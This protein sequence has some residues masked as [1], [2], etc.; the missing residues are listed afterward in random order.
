MF[1]LPYQWEALT[2]WEA[3]T[4]RVLPVR[5]A[6]DDE[7]FE[8]L[9][10]E[11]LQNTAVI[12]GDDDY[13]N[14]HPD[15]NI[16]YVY[17]FSSNGFM[18]YVAVQPVGDSGPFVTRI[19]QICQTCPLYQETYIDLPLVCRSNSGTEYNLAQSAYATQ[20]GTDLSQ[21][22]GLNNQDD[23]TVVIVAFS[24]SDGTS[25]TPTDE[26][27][28]CIY[29][30]KT[31]REKYLEWINDC[32]N[33]ADKQPGCDWSAQ[34]IGIDC[35]TG[36]LDDIIG[37][38]MCDCRSFGKMT[39]GSL[40]IV[41][42]A[43]FTTTGSRVT[44]VAA[45]TYLS[46]TVMFTGDSNGQLKKMKVTSGT[47]ATEYE[48]IAVVRDNPEIVQNGLVFDN[49][50][51]FIYVMSKRQ[52]TKVPVENCEQYTN[53][54][55]CTAIKGVGDPY[56][57]WCSLENKCSRKAECAGSN[58]ENSNRWIGNLG[59]CPS[60]EVEPAS[61]ERGQ[62]E[63]LS[64]TVTSL[65][66][67]SG[68]F[69][70]VFA[71]LGS[72][73]AVKKEQNGN[74]LACSTPSP[75]NVPAPGDRG[76]VRVKLSLLADE[77]DVNFVS[78]DFDF[79]EC[80]SF[81]TCMA[82]T[83]NSYGCDWCIFENKCS[84]D[85]TTCREEG[86][87]QGNANAEGS[88][89]RCPQITA[90]DEILIP[91]DVDQEYQVKGKNFP[92]ATSGQSG[93]QC[94]L[95]I[96]GLEVVVDGL[97]VD[98]QTVRCQSAK[99][100]YAQEVSNKLVP[101]KL[102][103]NSGFDVDNPDNVQVNLYKC[104]VGRSN[105][106]VCHQADLKYNC[107]WCESG[108]EEHKCTVVSKCSQVTHWLTRDKICPDPTITEIKPMAGPVE[109]GTTLTIRGYNL[110]KNASNV[111]EVTVVG[112]PCVPVLSGYK[113]AEQVQCVT[114]P[115]GS[116][117]SG[118]VQITIGDTGDQ[119][120]YTDTST[121][122]F[123]YVV[124]KIDGLNPEKGPQS[125]GTIVT[126]SGENLNAGSV[127]TANVA[128]YPCH[129]TESSYDAITCVTS[130]SD[131]SFPS[132]GVTVT[133]DGVTKSN[134]DAIYR[135]MADPVIQQLS[136]YEAFV[137]GG[138][139]IEVK[140]GN[141][142]I[143]HTRIMRMYIKGRYYDAECTLKSSTLMEC[144]TP[145]VSASGIQPTAEEPYECDFGF[146]MDSVATSNR[147]RGSLESFSY[148]PDPSY[149]EFEDGVKVYSSRAKEPLVIHGENL[150]LASDEH[151]VMVKIG[152]AS[153]QVTSLARNLL[154]CSPPERPKGYNE[155]K[156]LE[157]TIYHGNINV[158][159]G[160][161]K[162]AS[163]GTSG[164]IIGLAAVATG[165]IVITVIA[166]ILWKFNVRKSKKAV[167]Q[168]E[169]RLNILQSEMATQ[170]G[171]QED[172]QNSNYVSNS[173]YD[174][175][176]TIEDVPVE[177]QKKPLQTL[178]TTGIHGH[179][180]YRYDNNDNA[181]P[182]CEVCEDNVGMYIEPEDMRD[183]SKDLVTGQDKG[184]ET[185]ANVTTPEYTH[186]SN[187]Q[188]REESADSR[189]DTDKITIADIVCEDNG[190]GNTGY[191]EGVDNGALTYSE[192]CEGSVETKIDSIDKED[193]NN[194]TNY[195]V[196][197]VRVGVKIPEMRK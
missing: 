45:T 147:H 187:T 149:T 120:T 184:Y 83:N 74:Q 163:M 72:T 196:N 146:I 89:D 104:D 87:V 95:I 158:T 155:E 190:K 109:G 88:S 86:V 62:L 162:F 14:N 50:K 97:R 119:F 5:D 61:V 99:Y 107:G 2:R 60:M 58:D 44:A 40:D 22:L 114:S 68:G 111:K 29:P 164:V 67:T 128:G 27:A 122:D 77:T 41:K 159:I 16:E 19:V 53:C 180:G 85:T 98:E 56:C 43:A 79:Y 31:I 8:I 28:V 103:G 131:S 69:S 123:S 177:E 165:C 125:G 115:S 49:Q 18:Y 156:G 25:S 148:Y 135:Y 154:T 161:L 183:G 39:C 4:S 33:N 186:L 1:L 96:E 140:G 65:P 102:R 20:A 30:V 100:V 138:S 170:Q 13:L 166:V 94:V 90:G 63:T 76:F 118:K 129:I 178:T 195:E 145:D 32:S 188:K 23:K 124:S 6:N 151:D 17:G 193:D 152:D 160:I 84:K 121:E 82:C 57:G 157:V 7:A 189:P 110:G 194:V 169:I 141:L 185:L 46:H 36:T 130:A 91:V 15:F 11:I 191:V 73:E 54:E 71:N 139:K 35:G 51:N 48:G 52:I 181:D 12:R 34:Q 126:I 55:D 26:S 132:G 59:A 179:V 144:Y 66:E 176:E 112:F 173:I 70:C 175:Y 171:R 80:E 37:V 167:K 143:V 116:E 117:T 142:D 24:K 153:Y 182:H 10:S 38:N 113:I 106:G 93:Y 101:L 108:D 134:T 75:T 47:S 92:T 64:L 78:V 81:K 172:L 192:G 133:F 174:T 9:S 42:T 137:S 197:E 21:D 136:R 168:A 127:I 105:C 3:L 150:N